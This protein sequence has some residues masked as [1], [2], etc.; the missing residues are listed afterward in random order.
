MYAEESTASQA[1][2]VEAY[3]AS[4]TAQDDIAFA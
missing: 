4:L 1:K 2:A 3:F